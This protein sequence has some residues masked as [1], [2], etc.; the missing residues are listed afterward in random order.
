MQLLGFIAAVMA[1]RHRLL[2]VSGGGVRGRLPEELEVY[3]T[4]LME[5]G[6]LEYDISDLERMRCECYAALKLSKPQNEQVPCHLFL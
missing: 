4:G 3:L 6:T 5:K 1:F 2:L